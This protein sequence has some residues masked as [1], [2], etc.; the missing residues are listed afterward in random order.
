M[1]R[2]DSASGTSAQRRPHPGL[3]AAVCVALWAAPAGAGTTTGGLSVTAAIA[4]TCVINAASMAFGAYNPTANSTLD[5]IGSISVSCTN[6]TAYSIGLD[7]GAGT[8]ASIAT[9][10][11]MNGASTLQYQIFRDSGRSQNWGNTVG[12]DTVSGTGTGFAQTLT[13]Y[14]RITSGQPSARPGSYSDTVTVT[15]TY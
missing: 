13:A 1:P 14:G 12:T 6:G 3:A 15:I 11:M 2:S 4:A 8:G 5:A 10:V 9:R 7:K